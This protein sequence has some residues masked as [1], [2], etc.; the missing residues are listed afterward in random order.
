[1][2]EWKGFR[3]RVRF[4]PGPLKSAVFTALIF[5]NDNFRDKGVGLH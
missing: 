1:M 5:L 4:P 3:T 2:L